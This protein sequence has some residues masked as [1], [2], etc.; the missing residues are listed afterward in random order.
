M[1]DKQ[2]IPARQVMQASLE[3]RRGQT[4]FIQQKHT[5]ASFWRTDLIADLLAM[6]AEFVRTEAALFTA[7]RVAT[8]PALREIASAAQGRFSRFGLRLRTWIEGMAEGDAEALASF[9]YLFQRIDQ[10][11]AA[12]RDAINGDPDPLRELVDQAGELPILDVLEGL[13]RAGRRQ[14]ESLEWFGHNLA[15]LRRK[16]RTEGRAWSWRA[17]AQELLARLEMMPTDWAE[18][19]KEKLIE[20]LQ[21]YGRPRRVYEFLRKKE[22][23][24]LEARHK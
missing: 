16:F 6:Q 8:L 19:E 15:D 21:D 18:S 1:P 5:G 2:L 14:A 7:A 13:E 17:A 22:K 4:F 10:T 24:F 11:E 20:S 23:R 12:I 9:N 3:D